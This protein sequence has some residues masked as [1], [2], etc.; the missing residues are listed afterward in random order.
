MICIYVE[1]ISERLQYTLKFVFE[2]RG[3]AFELTKDRKTFLASE[4]I[5]FSYSNQIFDQNIAQ[6]KPS[7]L[8]FQENTQ[9]TEATSTIWN[10]QSFLQFKN[11]P[12][13]IASVFYV[14]V[15]YEE[16]LPFK[17]DEHGRFS[18]KNSILA[19]NNWLNQPICD[20]WSENIIHWL[21]DFHQTEIKIE[22]NF[23]FT[24]TFDIDNTFAFSQ[25]SKKQLLGG[26][27]KD[28]L[29]GNKERIKTRRNVLSGK[30]KDPFDTFDYISALKNQAIELKVFWHLGDFKQYDRNVSW[31]NK[32]HQKIIQQLGKHFE[33]GIHPSYFSNV[34]NSQITIEKQRLE[35]I[36]SKKTNSSRQHFLKLTFP[37]TYQNLIR[38][39][40]TNDYSM[41]FADEPGFRMGTAHP[42]PFFD[43]SKNEA[44]TLTIHPFIYMDGTLNQYKKTSP[45][46]AKNIIENLVAQVKKYGGNFVFIW[47]N[48]TIGEVGIWKNWKQ[49]FEH[50]I[51]FCKKIKDGI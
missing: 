1:N 10:G 38:A 42:Y 5:K 30:E 26:W 15:R 23:S 7:S 19:K 11:V 12:D 47:H 40:I 34:K 22:K 35:Q 27:F 6:I 24:P 44:T 43:L 51:S 3:I 49:V 4:N 2:V 29:K 45:E 32:I 39:N 9:N 16:Y 17:A 41:G 48:E 21:S 8:L 20:V 14:L 50:T 28:F 46:E 18:A 37:T 13:P 25:K 31:K 36:L 33:I